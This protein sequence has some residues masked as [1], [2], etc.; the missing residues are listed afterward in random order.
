MCEHVCLCVFCMILSW[1]LFFLFK[2]CLALSHGYFWS[3]LTAWHLP[4][5]ERTVL[6]LCLPFLANVLSSFA[7]TVCDVHTA[8]SLIV[9]IMRVFDLNWGRQLRH[10]FVS[11]S[12]QQNEA[13]ECLANCFI[14]ANDE[15]S[16]ESHTFKATFTHLGQSQVD[17]TII[18]EDRLR[19]RPSA[20]FLL[21]KCFII[22]WESTVALLLFAHAHGLKPLTFKSRVDSLSET[23]PNRWFS[24]CHSSLFENCVPTSCSLPPTQSDNYRYLFFI[25][26]VKLQLSLHLLELRWNFFWW[27]LGSFNRC[28]S[29]RVDKHLHFCM[30]T[31]CSI[32]PPHSPP[33]L[34]SRPSAG[35]TPIHMS[36][37][38][39]KFPVKKGF[40]L[41]VGGPWIL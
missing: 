16:T 17:H 10:W 5:C 21:H 11:C 12:E 26:E 30:S 28:P 7:F 1:M 22:E 39:S 35:A 20:D 13:L 34:P 14:R 3:F 29:Y 25:N 2:R 37:V 36:L 9:L 31:L 27:W 40:F 33:S 32:C 23:S 15:H 6:E 41:L 24:S 38:L 4:V 8:L 19:T 18:S